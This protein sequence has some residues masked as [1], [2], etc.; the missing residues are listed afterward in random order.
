MTTESSRGSWLG[1]LRIALGVVGLGVLVGLVRSVGYRVVLTTIA[2]AARWIPVLFALELA[3]IGCETVGAR[4]ALGSVGSRVPWRTLFRANL[5][6]QSIAN[7]APA[8]RVVNETIKATIVAPYVGLP[9]ATSVGFTIQAATL[10]SVGLFTLPCALAIYLRVGVS[11]WFWAALI[12]TV[13]LVATGLALRATTR[14]HGPGRWLAKKLPRFAAGASSFSEH[15]REVPLLAVGPTLALTGNRAFQSVQLGV[16]AA[17]VGIQAGALEALAAQGVNLVAAAVFVLVPGGLGT[18]DGAFSLGRDL[19]GA[20]L[21]QATS[22]ALLLRCSQIV[23][24]L[25][26]SV[27]ALVNDAPRDQ[28]LEPDD[29]SSTASASAASRSKK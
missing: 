8:P 28:R 1:W 11:V 12:H 21:A 3:R 20:T 5:I 27:A 17:A 24:L 18:T 13:V 6:G 15:A 25:V 19:M 22:M 2:S 26:G 4:L 23:T 14:A 10:V 16:A 9:A 7:F 29:G